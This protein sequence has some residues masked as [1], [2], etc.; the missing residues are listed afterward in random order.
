MEEYIFKYTPTED[1]IVETNM[2]YSPIYNSQT[3]RLKMSFDHKDDYQ[4]SMV[5]WKWP[6]RPYYTADVTKYFYDREKK[7][8][9]LFRDKK[10]AP[11]NIEFNDEEQSI[12]FDW[13]GYSC[14]HHIYIAKN[15]ENVCPD[16]R[17]QLEEIVTDIVQSGVYKVTLYPHCFFVQN[18]QLKTMDF[19]GSVDVDFPYID[20]KMLNGIIS[21]ASAHRFEEASTNG[22]VN[23]ETVFKNGLKTHITLWS[24]NTLNNIYRKLF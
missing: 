3:R 2:L 11:D 24:D 1:M 16:W 10:W 4:N 17:T 22:R 7:Y 23:F 21:S 18:G 15:L 14:N 6:E 8:L 13:P 9:R 19:Y 5:A 12:F 20:G